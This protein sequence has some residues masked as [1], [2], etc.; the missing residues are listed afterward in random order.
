MRGPYERLK[1]DLRRGWECPLCHR[2]EK[3][4]F[5]ITSRFCTCRQKTEGG[6]PVSMRLSEDGIRRVWTAPAMLVAQQARAERLA[7][8]EVET[9]DAAETSL[10]VNATEETT[11][12]IP[13][14]ELPPADA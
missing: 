8:G 9:A 7:A 10:G 11:E 14:S 4:D 13:A 3:T 6:T 5:L 1:Y 12:T 2:K